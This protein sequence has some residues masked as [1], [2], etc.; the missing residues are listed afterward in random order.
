LIGYFYLLY[1]K[2]GLSNVWADIL[3]R[4]HKDKEQ[5]EETFAI[6]PTSIG[7]KW[8]SWEEVLRAQMECK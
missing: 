3:S 6:T 1:H 5:I 8:P 7:L 4:L 2:E